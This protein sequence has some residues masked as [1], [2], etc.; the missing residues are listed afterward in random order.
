LEW[1]IDKLLTVTVDNASSNNMTISYLKNV[2]K[3]WRTNILLNE[4][5]HVR[6]CAHIINLIVYNGL[7]E[8]NVSVVKIQNAIRFVR[9][10]PSRQLAFKKCVENLHIECKKSLCL[11]IAT[12]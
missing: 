5:L 10:S 7:K 4:H 11:D 9:S 8:I 6:C 2:M 1:G 3:D 12:R